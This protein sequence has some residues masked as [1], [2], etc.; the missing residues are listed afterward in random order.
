M[1]VTIKPEIEST[2]FPRIAMRY[3]GEIV[4]L[5]NNSTDG[6]DNAVYAITLHDPRK[7]N[8]VGKF[9]EAGCTVFKDYNG[10]VVLRNN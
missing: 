6:T 10:E 3:D 4:L 1:E 8:C 5:V 7:T 9:Y 2:R